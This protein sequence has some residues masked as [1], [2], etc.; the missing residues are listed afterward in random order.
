MLE[1]L[2]TY[3]DDCRKASIPRSLP[4]VL[5]FMR[6]G[7]VVMALS[8]PP[9]LARAFGDLLNLFGGVVLGRWILGYSESYSEYYSSKSNP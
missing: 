8:G 5:L 4:Q 3:R 1:N 6:R 9:W 2:Q 7:G